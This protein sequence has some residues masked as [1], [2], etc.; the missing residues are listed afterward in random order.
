MLSKQSY[1]FQ[2]LKEQTKGQIVAQVPVA[3]RY[4][5]P[6]SRKKREP[7]EILSDD[8]D[9]GTKT[10]RTEFSTIW[11]LAPWVSEYTTF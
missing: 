6:M 1:N 5:T 11:A 3:G 4:P 2:S 10:I 7:S 9:I 8:L